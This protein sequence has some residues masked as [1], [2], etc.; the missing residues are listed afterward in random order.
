V[1]PR[2]PIK[3]TGAIFPTKPG[4]A[5]TLTP[6]HVQTIDAARAANGLPP[7]HEV[8]PNLPLPRLV[9]LADGTTVWAQQLAFGGVRP[10][11]VNSVKDA[12]GR[13]VD[14]EVL[15]AAPDVDIAY[16][17]ARDGHLL[18]DD[19]INLILRPAINRTY[20]EANFPSGQYDIVN[21][22][23]QFNGI[24]DA[25]LRREFELDK[26]EYWIGPLHKFRADAQGYTET[27]SFGAT[28]RQLVDPSYVP[29]WLQARTA[30]MASQPHGRDLKGLPYEAWESGQPL[31]S[32]VVREMRADLAQPS[33]PPDAER[34]ATGRVKIFPSDEPGNQANLRKQ[35]QAGDILARAG[36]H[37]EHEPRIP[38]AAKNPDY[39]IEGKVFDCY[40]PVTSD[41]DA[42]WYTVKQKVSKGQA[43]RTVLTL[44]GNPGVDLG[45][46]KSV[47][48]NYPM[49]GLKELILITPEGGVAHLWP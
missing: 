29:D 35:Q 7:L 5:V 1:F 11:L 18:S 13:I 46:L 22:G 6:E 3:G 30:A 44:Q 43:D 38:G 33:L 45:A 23:A 19:E 21:H 41:P 4:G 12:S 42:I 26:P 24:R 16:A 8:Y 47:F 37:V 9:T 39:L 10:V 32:G 17:R 40:A 15:L 20:S 48:D 31:P 28:Y 2:G 49:L 36:Y 27:A 14:G 25:A 34:L